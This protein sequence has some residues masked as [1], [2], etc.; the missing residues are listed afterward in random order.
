MGKKLLLFILC[1]AVLPLTSCNN[2]SKNEKVREEAPLDQKDISSRDSEIITENPPGTEDKES[3]NA[4]KGKFT[5]EEVIFDKKLDPFFE[6]YKAGCI[7]IRYEDTT[8]GISYNE[9]LAEERMSPLSTFKILSTIILLEEN[10]ISDLDQ[11]ITW[12]G[13]IYQNESWNSD[14]TLK[15]AFE[16]SV[17]WVYKSL[18]SNVENDKIKEYLDKTSYGNKDMSAEEGF[19]LDSSL[20]IS[21]KEQ[22]DFLEGVYYNKFNF[23]ES[24]IEVVKNL[25]LLENAEDFSIYG[26][27]GSSSG[28]TNLFVGFIEDKEDL[29][30]FS[31]YI[32]EENAGHNVAKETTY[33]IIENLFVNE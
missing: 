31:A 11:I 24:T 6:N 5:I 26:K 8:Q 2:H 9:Q 16:N 23:A 7:I 12:D 30:F 28:G 3:E 32:K 27:T 15:S 13:T 10:I 21:L 25:M 14:Q 19:W 29:F 20:K 17:V 22:I 1:L 4:E 33:K 18:L